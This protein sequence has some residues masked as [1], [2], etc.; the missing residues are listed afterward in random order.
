MLYEKKNRPFMF[1]VD[2]KIPNLGSTVPV[3]DK[4]SWN[5]GPSGW[6]LP[7]SNEHQW[8]ILCVWY[9]REKFAVELQIK[10]KFFTICYGS[11]SLHFLKT[12][13]KMSLLHI[14]A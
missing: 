6:D 11:K 2:R 14:L 3:G 7:V 1:S 10:F 4:A 13:E 12:E 5:G 8:W 9:A